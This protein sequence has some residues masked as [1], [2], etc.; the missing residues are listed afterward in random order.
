MTIPLKQCSRCGGAGTV[1][2][3]RRKRADG[4]P[5][6]L[7]FRLAEE[8]PACHYS[9]TVPDPTYQQ[10]DRAAR[11]GGWLADQIMPN[12]WA[13]APDEDRVPLAT[14]GDGCCA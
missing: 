2:R 11:S 4:S 12:E 3:E 10:P 1:L 5:D 14:E 9:G 8:C 7:D 13:P 6:P